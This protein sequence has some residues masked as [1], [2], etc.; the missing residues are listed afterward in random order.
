M[1]YQT[2]PNNTKQN[3][4]AHSEKKKSFLLTIDDGQEIQPS[5]TLLSND[6]DTQWSHLRVRLEPILSLKLLCVNF[7]PT[8]LSP[9]ALSSPIM[10]QNDTFKGPSKLYRLSLVCQSSTRLLLTYHDCLPLYRNSSGSFSGRAQILS[11]P[12]LKRQQ[13]NFPSSSLWSLTTPNLLLLHRV[14]SL[15][16][17]LIHSS[18]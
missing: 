18:G 17:H 4:A 6:A 1:Q 15:L 8:F 16:L 3:Q 13:L 11:G 5:T 14:L 9:P 10:T 12:S 2:I 7:P